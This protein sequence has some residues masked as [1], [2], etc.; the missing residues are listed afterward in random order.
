MVRIDRLAFGG[1]GVGRID[2]KACF[3]PFSAPGDLLRVKVVRDKRSWCEAEI[4]EIVEPSPLR[5]VPPCPVFGRC[6][7]CDWQHLPYAEQVAAKG[8]IFLD[9][10]WR[11]ARVAAEVIEPSVPAPQPF[12]Y[13]S[14]I[15]LKIRLAQ[16]QLVAGFYAAG[17]HFVIDI[18]SCPITDSRINAALPALKELIAASP[19]PDRLPQ[20]DLAVGDSGGI[21]AILHHIGERR[22]EMHAFLA[23]RGGEVPGL[24]G[25]Y[26]Q[27]G[28]KESLERIFGEEGTSY[29]IPEG[30]AAGVKQLRLFVGSGGFAQVNL[31]QNLE[32][33]RLACEWG[34]FSGSERLLDLYCGNGNFSL[35]L[36]QI[37][38]SVVGI[39]D[40][41]P[42]IDNARRNAAANSI[43]NADFRVADA[44]AEVRRLAAAGET[45][46]AVLLDP[47]RA[48]APET[49]RALPELG[50]QTIM[51]VSCDPQT[52]ARDLASLTKGGYRV[53]R[54]RAL[55]MFPQTYHMESI[56]LLGKP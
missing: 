12:N 35:P 27:H 30:L 7:G 9:S 13:R 3:V 49:V 14:R 31:S 15:Q 24:S 40:Y 55:D 45:F 4:R 16:G 50:A 2:G 26:L 48:G 37:V 10:L 42:S 36:S 19:E 1:A 8:D 18:E 5:T 39:E 43:E 41:A 32:L 34:G 44:A 46:D 17:T 22:Q 6:G 11:T 56:T 20:A 21:I 29:T 54:S 28:R 23:E 51:Y 53:I 38:A 25:L 52:L 47:P 33:I